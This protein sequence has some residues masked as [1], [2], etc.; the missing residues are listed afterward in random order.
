MIESFDMSLRSRLGVASLVLIST[1]TLAV[2]L[3]HACR[4][5]SQLTDPAADPELA[6]EPE[7]YS[8]TVVRTIDD[9]KIS[10]ASVTRVVRLGEKRR[11]EWTNQQQTHALIWRPD[12]GK[13]FLLDL[14]TRVYVERDIASSSASE[15]RAATSPDNAFSHRMNVKPDRTESFAQAIDRVLDESPS[16]EH[17]ESRMVAVEVIDHHRCNVYEQR[18][19]FPNG[20]IEVTRTF[21]AP[22]LAGLAL[23]I[24]VFAEG[25]TT[26]VITERRDIRTEVPTNAFVVPANFRKVDKLDQ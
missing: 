7:Q 2:V 4:N 17:V 1:A 10:E 21:R 20:H 15:L 11:E 6:G 24:E 23:R 3:F 26:K 9:G 5:G 13:A 22:D 16:P 12:L 25:G 14:D 8:A 18:A 19:T